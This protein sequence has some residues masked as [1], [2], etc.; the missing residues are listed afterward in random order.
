ML[1]FMS[2]ASTLIREARAGAGLSLRALADRADVSYTTICRIEHDQIDP[3]LGTLRKLL[4]AL[5]EELKLD[6]RPAPRGPQLADLADAWSTDRSGQDQPDWTRLRAFLDYLARYPELATHAIRSKPPVSGSP[7]F[8]NL[9][10]GVSEKIADDASTP[11]PAWTKRIPEL[12]QKWESLGTPRMQAAAVGATPPQL[13]A[14]HIFIPGT[15][16]WRHST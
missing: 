14:R 15:S 12:T 4:N 13:A 5:G 9:L 8:D 2:E 6:R 1:T 7:F 10:A 3:T 11:R 16:L